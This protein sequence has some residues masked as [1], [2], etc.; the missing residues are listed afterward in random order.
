MFLPY[1][2]GTC[3]SNYNNA[4]T[5]E[6]GATGAA[7]NHVCLFTPAEFFNWMGYSVR[8]EQYRYTLFVAWNGTRLK[9]DWDAVQSE[10]LYGSKDLSMDFDSATISEKTA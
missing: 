9:P 3:Q 7:N 8:A 4:W 1:A 6:T 10:E 5:H 2:Q